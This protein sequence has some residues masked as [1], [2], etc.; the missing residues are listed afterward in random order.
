MT[1]ARTNSGSKIK[2]NKEFVNNYYLQL[3]L[4][5]YDKALWY[6]AESYRS[7]TPAGRLGAA[8]I[9]PFTY[10]RQFSVCPCATAFPLIAPWSSGPT[11]RNPR[12]SLPPPPVSASQ[13]RSA[14]AQPG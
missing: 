13:L 4:T 9:R 8:F 7:R 5:P 12:V 1:V 6:P 10:S 14:R 11:C 2:T 3:C